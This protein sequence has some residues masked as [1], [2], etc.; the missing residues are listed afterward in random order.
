MIS[1]KKLLPQSALFIKVGHDLCNGDPFK[2]TNKKLIKHEVGSHLILCNMYKTYCYIIFLSLYTLALSFPEIIT[3]RTVDLF[4][5][6]M[7]NNTINNKYYIS[8]QEKFIFN[9]EVLL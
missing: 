7:I 8:K 5:G 3:Y 9:N 4:F 2:I 6:S 1:C